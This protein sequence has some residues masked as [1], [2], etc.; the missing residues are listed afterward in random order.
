MNTFKRCI[1]KRAA[2]AFLARIKILLASLE[3]PSEVRMGRG[4]GDRQAGKSSKA[5]HRPY[6]MRIFTDGW[7]RN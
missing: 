1:S 7:G 5:R 3:A 6:F 4:T 2:E